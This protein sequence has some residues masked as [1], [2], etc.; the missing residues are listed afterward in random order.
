MIEAISLG[1][2]RRLTGTAGDHLPNIRRRIGLT[3]SGADSRAHLLTVTPLVPTFAPG[4]REP[5]L[6]PPWLRNSQFDLLGPFFAVD[7][8]DV[9]DAAPALSTMSGHHL[10]GDVERC[11]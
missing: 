11:C 2:P 8:V 6:R 1:S 4:H 3:M 7:R 10:L 9:D 5:A